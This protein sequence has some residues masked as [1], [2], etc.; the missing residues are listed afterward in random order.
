M[1]M[2]MK[3][4]MMMMMIF[5]KRQVQNHPHHLPIQIPIIVATLKEKA[6]QFLRKMK[7]I[8]LVTVDAVPSLIRPPNPNLLPP[9]L[10]TTT[11]TTTL[12]L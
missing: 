2:K 1:K 7:M 3:T 6:I 5:V 10:L 4:M 8:C 12:L 9:L 11:T